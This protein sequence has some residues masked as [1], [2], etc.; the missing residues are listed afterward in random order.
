[1]SIKDAG[2]T[3]G[4]AF[5]FLAGLAMAAS[6]AYMLTNRISVTTGY[7]T[8]WGLGSGSFGLTLVPF[9]AGVLMVFLNGAS[10]LGWLLILLGCAI[11][12]SGILLNMQ[13]YF[14]RTTLYETLMMLGLIFGGLGLIGRSVLTSSSR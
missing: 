6:G 4:G 5:L 14:Q 3:P 1:M 11:I 8:F 2:G 13:I 7:W 12:L 10:K 9:L